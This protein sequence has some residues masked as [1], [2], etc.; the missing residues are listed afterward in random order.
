M[1]QNGT[2]FV[3][4]RVGSIHGSYQGHT[5]GALPHY[6][7]HLPLSALV[8]SPYTVCGTGS[9]DHVHRR[10]DYQRFFVAE[11]IMPRHLL[12]QH[13]PPPAGRA[14]APGGHRAR[15][16]DLVHALEAASPLTLRFSGTEASRE[17]PSHRSPT[18]SVLGNETLGTSRLLRRGPSQSSP[19]A[20][21]HKRVG[22]ASAA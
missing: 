20:R 4:T 1:L 2:G 10:W 19:D 17:M 5:H 8:L 7:V 13:V 12:T 14:S 15:A 9:Y 3:V 16:A 21:S 18:F 22:V 6:T 11:R